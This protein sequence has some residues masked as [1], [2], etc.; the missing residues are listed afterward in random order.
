MENTINKRWG[1]YD[2]S[3]VCGNCNGCGCRVCFGDLL[4]PNTGNLWRL[5]G[6]GRERFPLS[7]SVSGCKPPAIENPYKSQ[8]QG[9]WTYP[10]RT[11]PNRRIT[12]P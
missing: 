6:Q 9:G 10:F 3:D 8:G 1:Y 7:H 5:R 2:N 4:N 12:Y 11:T